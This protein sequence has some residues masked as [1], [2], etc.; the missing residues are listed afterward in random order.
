MIPS[1]YGCD[2]GSAVS[3]EF[4]LTD[5]QWHRL[6]LLLPNKPR[7]VP[8]VDDRR[9]ISGIIHVLRSGG[10]WVDAPVNYGPRKTL[11]NR[12]VRWAGKGVWARV[13]QA[14]AATGGPPAE[15]LLDSTHVKAHRCATGGKGGRRFR[16]SVSAVAAAPPRSAP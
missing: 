13:F 2:Q 11:Y 16:R 6:A 15:L 8:R 9:V 5:R 14:L 1:G 3:G 10:H 7:G 12:F 4:W